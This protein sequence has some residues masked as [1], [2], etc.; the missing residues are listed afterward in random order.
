[1]KFSEKEEYQ[2]QRAAQVQ[3]HNR[4]TGNFILITIL[5]IVLFF[6]NMIYKKLSE[7][8][9]QPS[10]SQHDLEI[11]ETLTTTEGR[12]ALLSET[13][14]NVEITGE[15]TFG[16]DIITVFSVGGNH[17]FCVFEAIDEGYWQEYCGKL[18]P[19]T[20]L[21]KGSVPLGDNTHVYDIY[22]NSID[23]YAYLEVLRENQTMPHRVQSM[24]IRFDENGIALMKLDPDIKDPAPKITAYDDAGNQYLLADG[25]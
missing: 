8:P 14:S 13:Y 9:E 16:K 5:A 19:K 3:M 18:L 12:K 4:H 6:S 17:S 20:D 2:K 23:N 11:A 21:I 22:L 24:Q 1:M 25:T 7:K 15:T 10:P